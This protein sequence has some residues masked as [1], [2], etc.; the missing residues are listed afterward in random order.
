MTATIHQDI[1]SR[2]LSDGA[3]KLKKKL[4]QRTKTSK[5]I[6]TNGRALTRCSRVNGVKLSA[7]M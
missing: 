1:I 3:I 2:I 7:I 6:A 4:M 5:K